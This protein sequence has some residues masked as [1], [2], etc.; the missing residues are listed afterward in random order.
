MTIA[1]RSRTFFY[2]DNDEIVLEGGQG[3]LDVPTSS[4]LA[5]SLGNAVSAATG[6]FGGCGLVPQTVLNLQSGG[7]ATAS[8]AASLAVI[9]G[10][11]RTSS[12]RPPSANPPSAALAGVLV[13][14]SISTRTWRRPTLDGTRRDDDDDARRRLFVARVTA[15]L[16]YEAGF[17]IGIVTGRRAGQIGDGR[18]TTPSRTLC[19]YA[20]AASGGPRAPAAQRR[21]NRPYDTARRRGPSPRCTNNLLAL[22]PRHILKGSS[23]ARGPPVIRAPVS[24]PL[25]E[26]VPV[27]ERR[28]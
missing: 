10:A 13:S 20:S 2:D 19:Y 23:Q 28:P 24:L 9:D 21:R 6:G 22:G 4:V 16:S 15:V 14:V 1:A 26:H 18:R 17:A 8:V 5:L 7:A 25:L 3:P 11:V 27:V 12:W